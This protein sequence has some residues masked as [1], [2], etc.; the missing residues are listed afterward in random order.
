M[1]SPVLSFH[2]VCEIR[3]IRSQIRSSKGAEHDFETV[4]IRATSIDGEAVELL[5]YSTKNG[6]PI[7][8]GEFE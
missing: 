5:L 1:S 6:L 7:I 2:N 3:V 4:K 8:Q